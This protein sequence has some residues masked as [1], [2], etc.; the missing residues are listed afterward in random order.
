M[1]C[2]KKINKTCYS[3]KSEGNILRTDDHIDNSD[4]TLVIFLVMCLK[5][6]HYTRLA[7]PRAF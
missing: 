6:L 7:K 3:N 5:V 1:G 4:H 2:T